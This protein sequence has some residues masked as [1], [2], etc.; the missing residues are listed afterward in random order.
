MY[1]Q[2]ARQMSAF[3]GT[4]AG[5][6]GGGGGGGGP[7][8]DTTAIHDDTA[9]EISLITEK[10]APVAADLIIIED[11]AAANVKKRVQLTNA[12][13]APLRLA[14][15]SAAAPTY[16]FS[17]G[18]DRGWYDN[19]GDITCSVNG[20]NKMEIRATSIRA[21]NDIEPVS[22][23]NSNL[24]TATMR[25]GTVFSGILNN[26]DEA[27]D[28]TT[29]NKTVS[30]ET[31]AVRCTGN[32]A[33][34]NTLTFPAAPSNGDIL[35]VIEIGNS[36]VAKVAANAGH[37]L[38][39]TT[40]VPAGGTHKYMFF[41]TIWYLVSSFNP[42]VAATPDNVKQF[43]ADQLDSPVNADFVVN[44]L[45]PA[46]AD[47]TNAALTVRLFD[48]TAE[49][50]VAWILR[51]PSTATNIVLTFVGRAATAPGAARTVGLKLYK[52]DIADNAAVAAW[53]A[54]TA[55]T[56]IDITTNAFFQYD[57]QTIALSTLSIT[58]GRETQFEMTRVNPVGG[59][60]L[61]GDWALL[62][63]GVEFT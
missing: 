22:D 60:E 35:T 30:A 43:Y 9:G 41:G 6:A 63:I 32:G 50:G 42:T 2:K 51:P 10:T 40:N 3:Q 13:I 38:D 5:L 36:S 59:T 14:A 18:T 53:S 28:L 33:G 44:A 48:D 11:S 19:G 46:A 27:Q 58:A 55:L 34:G 26:D 21:T 23:K 47:A 61:V 4:F 52:R 25:F 29:G 31:G 17:T 16:S 56:D 62:K 57:T 49:E 12:T 24:G 37:T 20:S 15:G 1:E 8:T 54:G 39:Q 7:G 45:A